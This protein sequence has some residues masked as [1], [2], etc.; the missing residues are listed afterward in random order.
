MFNLVSQIYL[1]RLSRKN[2]SRLIQGKMTVMGSISP[3]P[4]GC[5]WNKKNLCNEHDTNYKCFF[6]SFLRKLS[7]IYRT[8]MYPMAL[9]CLYPLSGET[10]ASLPHVFKSSALP[11]VPN[12][13]LESHESHSFPPLLTMPILALEYTLQLQTTL[14]PSLL[15]FSG[16]EPGEPINSFH[17]SRLSGVAR[18]WPSAISEYRESACLWMTMNL[19][20]WSIFIPRQ[21]L[22]KDVFQ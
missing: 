2:G 3:Y 4:R 13:I 9:M 14:N 8:K 11:P 18:Y 22:E 7:H 19:S 21:I 10:P 12:P 16:N 5:A 6:F 20:C 17:L 1:H 15:Q